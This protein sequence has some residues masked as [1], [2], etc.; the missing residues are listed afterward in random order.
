MITAALNGPRN[1]PDI[2][3]SK[4][5][6]FLSGYAPVRDSN[7]T[8][9]GVLGVDETSDFVV[10]YRI[11]QR[12]QSRGSGMRACTAKNTVILTAGCAR[13]RHNGLDPGT[14]GGIPGV[15]DAGQYNDCSS[16]VVVAKSLAEAF[17]VG[18]NDLPV[19]CNIP[20]T[21]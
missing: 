1:S 15:I 9:V 21:N 14:I 20:G 17:G 16:L 3:T 6:S 12:I 11:F 19:S 5:G 7:G 2:Y 10:Q 18:I 13:Y 8:V 4:W